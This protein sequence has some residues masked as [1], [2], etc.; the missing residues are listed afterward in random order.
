MR[1]RHRTRLLGLT[2][3]VFAALCAVA[4]GGTQNIF[5]PGGPAARRIADVGWF[6]IITFSAVSLFMWILIFWLGL[7]TRGT[8]ARHA[9]W[10]AGGGMRWIVVGGLVVPGVILA[11]TFIWGLQ[12]MSAFPIDGGADAGNTPP[13]I[14]VIGHQWWWE[15]QYPLGRL[16]Q[17][18]TTANDIHFP[19]GQPVDI[20]LESRDVIHSFWVPELH[21]KVDLI[22][23]LVNRIRVQSDTPRTFRGE[24]AEYCG[25]Q[26]AHMI[27]SLT[28]DTPEQ[29]QAW[30]AHARQ[31]AQEPPPDNV[32]A[33]RGEQVF[34]RAACPLCHTIHGTDAQGLVG[35]DLTH[36]AIRSG[37]AANALSNDVASMSAW[38]THAQSLK[39]FV[40]MPNLTQFKGTELRDL[41][42]YLR[43]LN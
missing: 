2:V 39:P 42:A 9:P 38:V 19:A 35:P 8:L 20:S 4:C 12:T 31:P 33:V 15:V 11:I 23:G 21:G 16:D 17:L 26:H 37:I 18:V 34:M 27:L 3:A 36:V 29:F 1:T 40:R 10:D 25:P 13:M 7:R 30:L 24:C 14:R 41:V 32:A 43:T 22:P 5:A 28:A 6:V